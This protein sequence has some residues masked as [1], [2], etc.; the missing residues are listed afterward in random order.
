MEKVQPQRTELYTYLY[1]Y[2]EELFQDSCRAV[3]TILDTDSG[4]IWKNFQAAVRE[5]LEKTRIFQQQ[6][7][8]GI[9][10]YLAFSPM[11]YAPFLDRLE[12]RID[13]LDDG[14][15]LDTQEAS[16]HYHA[17]FLQDRFLQDLAFLYEKAAEKFIRI[18][19]FEQIQIRQN[20]AEYYD[21]LLFQMIKA[22]TGLILETVEESGVHAADSLRIL[23][24]DYMDHAVI[25]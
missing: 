13:A 15:Y 20:Y 25:L 16:A 18:Q 14:F 21:A 22:L 17:D 6:K 10:H 1:T 11:Q 24:G 23:C 3:Q 5:C 7:Q 12:L 4:K 9:L 8:K 2:M 19:Y